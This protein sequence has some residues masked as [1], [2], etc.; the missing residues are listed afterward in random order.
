[1]Y[2]NIVVLVEPGDMWINCFL[3]KFSLA[4]ADERIIPPPVGG[5]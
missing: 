2:I 3:D 5:F 4:M 1:M